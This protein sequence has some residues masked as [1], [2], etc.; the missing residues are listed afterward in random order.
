MTAQVDRAGLTALVGATA[1]SGS[2]V[3]MVKIAARGLPALTITVIQVVTAVLVLGGFLAA[4]RSA[5]RRPTSALVVAG[6]LEPGLAFPLINAGLARTSGTHGALIIGLESAFVVVL[7]ALVTRTRLS[8]RVVVGLGLA[9]AGAAA[10]A[11]RSGGTAT[12]LGDVLVLP[13]SWSPRSTCSPCS[14]SRGRSTR[15]C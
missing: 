14:R 6:V 2:A 8:P 13:V 4:R 10:I 12:R 15:S 7:A 9:V 5:L 1:A 3:V 11:R